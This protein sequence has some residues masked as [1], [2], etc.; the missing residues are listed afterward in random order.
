MKVASQSKTSSNFDL[1]VNAEETVQT[2]KDRIAASQLV[3]FPDQDLVLNG[4]VLD[5]TKSLAEYDVQD[6]STL[7]FVIKATEDSLVQ[8]LTELLKARDLTSDELGL[9]YC[10]KHG[11]SIS[12]AFK[13]VGNTEKF[14][15][16]VKKQKEFSV[17]SGRVALVRKDT[18]IKPF[19]VGEE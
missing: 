17:E 6:C 12:Q 16:F 10:Y 7:D 18:A 9:L 13:T 2:V 14:L 8:Q 4:E 15:D 1:T 19:S 5:E 3:P 11:V